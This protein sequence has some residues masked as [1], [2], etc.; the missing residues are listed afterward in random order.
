[1]PLKALIAALLMGLAACAEPGPAAP[2][3]VP[4]SPG[5]SD[6]TPTTR[7]A[8]PPTGSP[9]PAP[10]TSTTPVTGEVP[11][12]LLAAILAD[13]ST[14]TGEAPQAMSVVTAESVVWPDGSLGCPRPGDIYQ[15]APTPGYRVVV[16]SEGDTHD[17]RLTDAGFFFVCPP[18]GSLIEKP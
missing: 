13:L 2:V 15:P 16:E 6:L 8:A 3:T 7:P 4:E 10:T 14:R 17:Y 1:M 12:D 9:E 5:S 11:E 18:L